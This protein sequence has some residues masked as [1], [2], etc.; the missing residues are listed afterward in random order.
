MI[1]SLVVYLNANDAGTGFYNLAGQKGAC[2]ARA[3]LE[4]ARFR[5]TQLGKGTAGSPP[6]R[7][8]RHFQYPE[9]I[10]SRTV[11]LPANISPTT[12]DS[13]GHCNRSP[14][15]IS[16]GFLNSSRLRGRSFSSCATQSRSSEL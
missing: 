15:I 1:S 7:Q 13:G 12:A 11:E 4:G 5:P 6:N 2:C 10:K 8:V 14:S 16:I 3:C 9:A